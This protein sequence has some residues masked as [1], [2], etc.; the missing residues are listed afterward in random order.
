[1]TTQWIR[2]NE[3]VWEVLNGEALLVNPAT[4]RRWSLNAT[5]AEV[6]NACDGTRGLREL[7]QAF[8]VASG[9]NVR[10]VKREIASFCES[11]NKLGLLRSSNTSMPAQ[12]ATG[13]AVFRCGGSIP[14]MFRELSLGN[15]ARRR[16]SPRGNSGPG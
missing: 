7:T 12:T 3:V 6:W 4:D 16:P 2:T 13:G 8:A 9:R 14:P 10:V 5:A 1:M 11:L 15:G